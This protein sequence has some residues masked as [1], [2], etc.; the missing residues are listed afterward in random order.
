MSDPL[1]RPTTSFGTSRLA[2]NNSRKSPID[3]ASGE[4]DIW[5][6]EEFSV[7]SGT[8]NI[9]PERQQRDSTNHRNG[10]MFR[11]NM[12]KCEEAYARRPYPGRE[13]KDPRRSGR[14]PS[15]LKD[16]YR[17][18]EDEPAI[19]RKFKAP[20][21][22]RRSERITNQKQRSYPAHREAGK[23][24]KAS[25]SKSPDAL[26]GEIT[27][28]WDRLDRQEDAVKVSVR[29]TPQK[30]SDLFASLEEQRAG[31]EPVEEFGNG[32]GGKIKEDE[33]PRRKQGKEVIKR[34]R[35]TFF[36]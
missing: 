9:S 20:S 24:P 30:S 10:D 11:G 26:R 5:I 7:E 4:D 31:R 29:E 33:K 8:S 21:E 18:R 35:D 22:T 36:A 16:N 27:D 17:Y 34:G 1:Y 15:R 6:D 2:P 23:G 19:K 28:Y 14:P 12:G 13:V 3:E 25:E 32:V